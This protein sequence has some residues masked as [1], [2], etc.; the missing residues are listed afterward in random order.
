MRARGSTTGSPAAPRPGAGEVAEGA[1]RFD[2]RLVHTAARL[3]YLEDATQAQIAE[4]LGT[5]R[6][7]VSRL[8]T[9]ARRLGVVRIEV[10]DPDTASAG[11][12]PARLADRLGLRRVHLTAPGPDDR[13]DERLARAVGPALAQAGLAPGD[14]LLVSSGR[15]VH[16]AAQQALP[17]LP[18]VLIAPTVGGQDEPEAWYQTNE[19]TRQVAERV[20][21]RPFFLYAPAFPGRELRERLLEDEST[22]AVLE[23]WQR[24][25]CALL[26]VGAPPHA[27]LTLPGPLRRDDPSLRRAVGDICARFYDEA[28]E[29]LQFPGADR[30]LATSLEQLRRTPVTI[31]VAGGVPKVP[32]ILAGA[33]A[34][35]FNELVTDPTTATALLDAP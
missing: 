16:A 31:A 4:E 21:G 28:G 22:R 7:T 33:R 25:R 27:R 3:Y 23:L 1:G 34:G 24:A 20:G 5:S 19:L 11:D 17:A 2:L 8:L 30:L 12:L 35:W 32:S 29:P 9:E 10:V 6:P 13:L 18:G 15:S 26:G 14:V